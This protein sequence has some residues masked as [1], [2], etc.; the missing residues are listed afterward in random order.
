MALKRDLQLAPRVARALTGPGRLPKIENMIDKTPEQLIKLLGRFNIDPD[1]SA[2]ESRAR[3]SYAKL[4]RVIEEGIEPDEAF[5]ADYE[6][7]VETEMVQNLRKMAKRAIQ[8]YR[9]KKLMGMGGRFVWVTVADDNVC[10]SCE[11]RHGKVKTMKAWQNVGLPGS[12][13]LVC[14]AECRCQLVPAE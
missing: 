6:K 10:P 2:I 13:A 3:R 1:L 11:P 9:Q 5:W 14:S 7:S 12:G 4:E 8:L